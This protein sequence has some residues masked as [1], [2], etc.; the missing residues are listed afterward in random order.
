MCW[1]IPIKKIL[2]PFPSGAI[3]Y[4]SVP[5]ICLGMLKSKQLIW[6][7][8]A[9][10]SGW[11]I[12]Q[13]DQEEE[14]KETLDHWVHLPHQE[15]PSCC[16]LYPGTTMARERRRHMQWAWGQTCLGPCPVGWLICGLWM[17]TSPSWCFTF[18][19]YKMGMSRI[20]KPALWGLGRINQVTQYVPQNESYYCLLN[21]A[22]SFCWLMAIQSGD[23]YSDL[24]KL[25]KYSFYTSTFGSGSTYPLSGISNY[26][27]CP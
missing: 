24:Q 7:P 19:S 27:L 21:K 26:F 20:T 9:S 12:F 22:S 8:G 11:S 13:R 2:V 18:P 15:A 25:S 3:F 10:C 14:E 5:E 17:G 23:S 6:N 4:Q 1:T 16:F